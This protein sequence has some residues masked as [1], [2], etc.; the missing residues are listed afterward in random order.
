M[1]CAP[2]SNRLGVT[3]AEGPGS[4]SL[5]SFYAREFPRIRTVGSPFL[6]F[7]R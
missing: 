7:C 2:Y 1:A 6:A 5:G 4:N 3:V